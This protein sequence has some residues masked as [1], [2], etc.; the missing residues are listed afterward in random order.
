MAESTQI[1]EEYLPTRSAKAPR[2]RDIVLPDET[3]STLEIG[4]FQ[5]TGEEIVARVAR[6]YTFVGSE[7]VEVFLMQSPDIA[8]TLLAAAPAIEE[9]FGP[10]TGLTLQVLVDQDGENDVSLF[11]RI[12]AAKPVRDAIALRKRFYREWWMKQT[13]ALESALN[14]EVEST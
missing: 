1:K 2:Q 5:E 3:Q 9:I 4:S 14:F 13:Q 6:R 10:E 11:A 12:R 7:R 8:R